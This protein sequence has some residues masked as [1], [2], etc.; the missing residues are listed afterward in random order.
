M[1]T[2]NRG[3]MIFL[4]GALVAGVLTVGCGKKEQAKATP[5]V[6]V[7]TLQPERVAITSELPGRTS[8]YLMAEVHPQVNGIVQQRLF[9]EGSRCEGGRRPLPD[10]PE[11]LPGRL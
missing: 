3:G 7:V 11:A 6:A 9:T 2:P 10:R 8:A 4:A 5:E 1:Q